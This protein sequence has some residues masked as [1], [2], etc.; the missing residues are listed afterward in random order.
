MQITIG[1][2]IYDP[3][4]QLDMIIKTM[5]DYNKNLFKD[6]CLALRIIIIGQTISP[7]LFEVMEIF[8]KEE[9]VK[10]FRRTT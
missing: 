3:H 6:V 7:P 1:S 10:R 8:G 4:D 5:R 9:C 2:I